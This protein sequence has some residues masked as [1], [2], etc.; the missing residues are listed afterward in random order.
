[1]K[2]KK[3]LALIGCGGRLR[4]VIDG[5][6]KA[7]PAGS[8]EISDLFDPDSGSLAAARGIAPE[9]VCHSSVDELLGHSDADWVAIGSPNSEHAWQVVAALDA[10]RHVFCE[11]PLATSPEDC[12]RI[13]DAVRRNPDRIFFFGLVL[14]YSPFY[15]R[16]K[17]LLDA[18]EIGKIISF[19]FNETLPFYHGGYI[20]GNW[21]R[22][23]AAAGTHLL[24][25]CCHDLDIANWLA[26]SLPRR[27]ASFGGLAFFT[28]ENRFMEEKLGV[29]EEGR[30]AYHVWPDPHAITPFNDDKDIV[31]HQ[32]AILEYRNGVKGTFHTNCHA[33]LPERRFYLCGT[34]GSLRC[35]VLTAEIEIQKVGFRQDVVREV[36]G[37]GD[38]HA[39]ADTP[40]Q[41][42]L[43]SSILTGSAPS[44][45]LAEGLESALTAFAIDEALDKGCVVDT[46]KMA[47]QLG[48]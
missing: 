36:I 47:A 40:M 42:A 44:A 18:G 21:R 10:G 12:E 1:M 30:A 15:R 4:N 35:D 27:A 25:K 26:G 34:D 37:Q 38:G 31:D 41:K 45:G 24:E 2:K 19:E 9:A 8:I 46:A 48:I 20:H 23:R 39:G 29:D 14:R 32:V 43:A 3:K 13:R 16:V 33:G 11:K 22:H 6:L 5:T 17:Q 28:P 7:A